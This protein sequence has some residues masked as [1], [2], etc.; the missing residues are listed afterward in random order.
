MNESVKE[1]LI[2]NKEAIKE[3]IIPLDQQ[4]AELFVISD[5]NYHKDIMDQY[6]HAVRSVIIHYVAT[7]IQQPVSIEDIVMLVHS[8]DLDHFLSIEVENVK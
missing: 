3:L 8:L 7:N 6:N 5:R 2:A 4:K 1:F